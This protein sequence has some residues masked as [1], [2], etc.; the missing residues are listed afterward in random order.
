MASRTLGDAR[1]ATLQLECEPPSRVADYLGLDGR[2]TWLVDP[3]WLL[4]ERDL[5]S[6]EPRCVS[7][8]WDVHG[9]LYC[10]CPDGLRRVGC[11]HVL[12]VGERHARTYRDHVRSSLLGTREANAA[13]LAAATERLTAYWANH[14]MRGR[15]DTAGSSLSASSVPNI[16]EEVRRSTQA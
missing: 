4:V 16:E 12:A 7:V 5:P 2:R 11:P 3:D 15:S 6:D 10:T 9:V 13:R 14:R 1:P 8:L